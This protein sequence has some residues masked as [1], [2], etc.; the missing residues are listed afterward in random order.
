[1]IFWR[2][3]RKITAFGLWV[4]AGL[5]VGVIAYGAIDRTQIISE[6]MV[7]VP[8]QVTSEFWAAI[9]NSLVND[10][11]GEAIY[12]DFSD[13]NASYFSP[14]LL[15]PSPVAEEILPL[16]EERDSFIDGSVE[17]GETLEVI[18]GIDTSSTSSSENTSGPTEITIPV[19]PDQSFNE[20][21]LPIGEELY[22]S[23]STET[24]AEPIDEEEVVEDSIA[25]PE[26]TSVEFDTPET[27]S[28]NEA[29]SVRYVPNFTFARIG[30][31]DMLPPLAT[32][33]FPLAQ[34][35]ITTYTE[36]EEEE[37]GEL[38]STESVVTIGV[39]PES[40]ESETITSEAEVTETEAAVDAIEPVETDEEDVEDNGEQLIVTEIS[41]QDPAVIEDESD[42]GD[43]ST[44]PSADEF[45]DEVSGVTEAG[46]EESVT[47]VNDREVSGEFES[48][49]EEVEISSSTL[50]DKVV[51]EVVIEPSYSP[52][53]FCVEVERCAMYPIT[54]SG[55]A[56]PEFESGKF[57]SDVTLRLS[58]AAR[59][60]LDYG[61]QQVVIDYR[62]DEGDSWRAATVI[63]IADET[64][65]AVN[66]GYYLVSLD[67]PLSQAQLAT[68]EVRVSYLGDE[69]GLDTVFVESLW[70]EVSAASF[71]EESDP[72]YGTDA[73][74]Y[75]RN[76]LQPQFMEL[77]NTDLDVTSEE[78]PKFALSYSPQG[79]VLRRIANAIFAENEYAVT[80]VRVTDQ[81]DQ[82]IPVPVKIDYFDDTTWSVT[83]QEQPQKFVPGK[84]TIELTVNE[85][86]TTYVDE[87]EFYWG[88]LAVNT[89]KG[90]Y[91]PGDEVTFN[92]AALTD[93]GDTICD[94][95]LDL[96]VIT[97]DNSFYEVPVE[98]SGACG[99]NNVTDIPDYSAFFAETNEVGRY[100]IQLRHRNTEGEVIHKIE[101]HFEVAEY[102]PYVIERTA[103]TRIYPPAP[104]D[105]S[106]KVSANRSFTGD[107]VEKVPRGFVITEAGNAV[108]ETL[109][110]YTKI[111]W[112]NVSLE[113]GA[114]LELSYTFDAPDIS[115]YLY[116]LGPLSLDGYEEL[117][118]WQIASDALSAIASFTG[119]RTVAGANLNQ[120]ASPLEWSTSSLDAYYFDHATSTNS[121][122]VIIRQAGD[123]FLSA[124]LPQER[125][126]ANNSRTRVGL[127]V[128][129]NGVAIPEGLGRSGYIRNQSGHAESSSHINILLT[130]LSQD[131]VIT[132]YA[133]GLTTIDAGDIVNVSGQASMFL[134]YI[135]IGAGVFSATTT[136]TTNSTDLNQTTE[137]PFAWTETR[138]DSGFVHS[139]SVNPDQIIISDPGLYFVTVNIPL[140]NNI[141]QTNILGQVL[142]DGVLVPGGQFKQ[143][144]ARAVGDEN[145]GDSS[146]HWTGIV[147][148]TTTNQVLTITAQREARA[149]TVTVTSGS[150]GS[151]YVRELP[152]S[153][154]L[155]LRG[156]NLVGGTNWNPAAAA[157]VQWDNEFVND[158]GIFTHST[159]TN[160][161]QVTVLQ[162]G[163]YF[164][165]YNDALVGTV[166]RSNPRV[167]VLVNGTPYSGAETKSHYIRNQ[168][169]HTESSGALA[170]ILEG[171]QNGDV[172]TVTT[173]QEAAAGTLNDSTDALL[174]LWKKA[175]IDVRPDAPTTYNAPF[176]NIRFASTTPYFDFSAVD[177]D[178]TSA[179]E[180]EFS[181][182]TSSSFVASSTYISSVDTEF[183]NTASSSDTSP[184]TEGDIIRFQ[185][186]SGDAL[187]DLTTYYWR[188]RAR[189]VSGSGEFGDWSTTQ[190]LTVDLAQVA[191][192]WFQSYS[193]QFEGNSLVGT[194]SSGGD[195]V[196]VDATESS[197]I[198]LV[199]GEGS[200]TTPRYR[201]WNGT[202]WGVEGSAG[203]IGGAV[204]WVQTAAGV[205]RDE[206]VLGTVD[207]NNNAYAQIY[208]ASTSSWGNVVLLSSGLTGAAYR[209]VAVAY[210]STSGDAMAVSCSNGTN[211]V[212]RTWNGSSWSATSTIVTSSLNNCNFVE[213]ASDPASDE[214]ILVTR[215]TGTQYEAMVWDGTTWVD[216]R[217]IGSSAKLI[218]EGIS[219]AYETSGDQAVIVVSNNTANNIIYTTWNGVE[220]STNATQALGN[221]F[222]FGRLVQDPN[223]DALALCYIDEDNDIGVLRWNG[224]VWNT[225]TELETAGNADTG[226]PVD[227]AF[228][229]VSGRGDYI[230]A[231]YSDTIGLRYRTATSSN[232]WGTEASIDTLQDSFWV[233]TER[234]GDGTIVTVALD[235]VADNLNT[236]RW[237]GSS[238]S[239][240]ETL[241]T[242]LSS[243]IATPYEIFDLSAKLFQFS[244]GV[245]E[246]PPI[247]FTAVPNQPT[248]G[249]VTFDTTEPFGTNV[250]VRIKYTNV[251]TCDSYI[252]NG[253]LPGNGSGFD[254]TQSPIDLTGLSTSTYDQICLEATLTTQDSQSAALEEWT[255]SWVRQPKL[256]QSNYRW[257]V[258]GSFLTPS[259]PWPVGAVELA[260]NEALSSATAINVNDTIRLRVALEGANVTLPAFSDAFKLQFAEGFTCSPALSWQDVGDSASSTALWRGYENAIVGDDWY[261]ASWG[262]RIKLTVLNTMV[263]ES[264]TDFPVYVDLGNLPSGFFANVQSDGDDIRI[265][266]S[267]GVTELPFELV[268][269][270]TGA[271]T[272]ELHFKA[273]LSSTTDSEFFLYYNNP[274]ASGYAVT[275]TYGARNVWTNNF[276]LRYAMDDSPVAASPQFKDS[277]SNNNNAV[278]YPGMTAGDVVT[279]QL[280]QAIDL[281]G[282]DGGT[283][284]TA[285]AYT[286]TF[287]ASMWWNTSGDGFAIA[288]PGGANEKM[289]P[290]SSPANRM[291]VRTISSSDTTVTNPTDGT[292]AHVVVTRD[293]SNK[294]DL[295]LN[296]TRTRLYGDAAQSGTSDWV[297]F[298]GETSQGF[299]GLLDELR[300]A[301]VQRSQGWVSTEF[302]NQSN[303]IG[304]YSLSAEELISDGRLL[305][306]T[307]LANSDYEET[308]EEENPTRE[309]QNA[310]PVG[311]ESEWDFVLQN[312]NASA[313]TNYCFR[314][315]YEDGSQFSSY[316]NY[317]RLITNA[318]PLAPTLYAPFDNEQL[319]STSP[320]FEFTADDDLGDD[321]AYQIQVSTDVAFGSTVVDNNSIA[322]FAL[323]EN[324][325]QPSEKST[326]TTGETIRY[327][328]GTTLSNGQTYWWRVRAQDPDGSGA[329]GEWST[330]ESF[331]VNTATVITTWFQTTA[332][333][334][335]TNNLLDAIANSGTNDTG[336]ESGFTNA[337]TTSTVIDYDDRDTG[338]AWGAF[339]FNHNVTSGSISYYIE[340]NVGGGTFALVPDAAL[341][342]NSVGFTSSP[343]S[344]VNLNTTTYNEL[345]IR[346]VLTGN[347]T[348]PRLQDWTVTW[349]ETIDI[350]TL[351]QP[352]DNAK[353]ATTGP[354]FTFF[355]SDP[356]NDDLQYE[357]QVSGD[358][359]FSAP[360]TFTSGV[361]AGFINTEDGADTSPF[362]T[363]DVIQYTAQTA[364][365]N[366]NTYWWRVRARDPLGG[367][368]WSEYSSPQSFTVDTALTAS[369]WYQ[370]TGEQ[371]DT[372]TNTDIETT[373][374]GAQITS[375]IREVMTVYGE[376]TG[377][378]PQYRLWN[379]TSWGT[380]ASAE[381]VGAQIR[382]LELKA[383]PAR[384]E[385]ALGTLGSDLAVN[386]QIYNADTE[387]WGDV[388]EIQTTSV[389]NNK[390]T[391]NLAYESL[392]GD[393]LAVACDGVDAVWSVW[394]G[395]SW[396]AT[397]TLN[398]TNAN[399][400][401]YVAIASDPASDEIIAMFRHTNTGT[402]DF[403][404]VVWNGSTWGNATQL[405][406]LDN[407]TNEGMAVVYEE[408]GNQAIIVASNSASPN[409]IYDTWNG[410]A[411]AGATTLALGDRIEWANLKRDVGSDT[412]ALCYQDN[413][414]DIGVVFWDGSAWGTF[415]ELNI[416]GNADNGRAVD[417]EFET[418]GGRDG[419]LMVGYSSTISTFYQFYAT[420]SFSGETQVDV[421]TDTAEVNMVRA[422]DGLI[423]LSAYDDALNPDRIDHSRW[424]GTSWTARERF[425]DNASL[426]GVGIYNGGS[427]M[428]PQLYPNFT[429]GAIRSTPIDFAAGSGPRWDVVSWNDTTP[430]ASVIEYRVYYESAPGVFTLIPDGDL[431]GNTA[432]FTTSPIDIS[433]LD[434]T[435]YAVLQL[436]AQFLCDSGDC[437]TLEDWTVAWSEGITVSGI[438][439]EYNGIATTTS[440]SVAV[441]VNG[442]LQT[443]KTG[444]ILG[445]G[446]WSISNVT[447]FPGDTVTVFVDGAAD[448]DEA[449]AIAT[450]NGVGNLSGLELFKR[451]ISI[452]GNNT[453]TTTNA[454]FTGYD[455]TDDEDLFFTVGVG[456]LLSVCAEATCGDAVLRVKTGSAYTPGANVTT[457]NFENYGT[458]SP[459]TSTVRVAGDWNNQGT[460]TYGQSTVIFTATSTAETIA[461]ASTTISFYNLTFGETNGTAAWSLSNKPLSVLGNLA[462]NYG[463]LARATSSIELQGN[464]A[465]GAA[466]YFSGIGTTTFTGSGSN[467]WGD[468]KS[469]ASSTN[470]G[471]VVIDGTTKTVTLAGSVAADSVTI[472]ADDTLNSSGSGYT[473]TVYGAW[474]N[475]NAF[476][477]QNGTVNFAGTTSNTIAR[478]ASAF[479]NLTFSGVGGVWSFSS[480][481]L[482]VNGNLTIATGT[483]TLP[484]G[485]TTI[486]GSFL[487]TGGTF[488][489]NNGEVRMTSSAAGRT[490]TQSAT[491]FLNAFY[492]LAFTGSG[493]WSFTETNATTTRDLR[494]QSGTV[495]FPSGQL[496]VGGDLVVTGAGAFNHNNGEVVLIVQDADA[497]RTNG[498]SLNNVRVIGGVSSSWYD[499]NWLYRVPVTVQAS[500]IDTDLSN[501]P[502]YV[503]LD[504][505]ST[506]FFSNVKSDGADIRVTSGDGV[507]EVPREV[508]SINTGTGVGELHF[509]AD[510][511]S[512][513][514]DTTFYIYYGNAA[515]SDY[516]QNATY[517][518]NNVWSNGYVLV[519]HMDDLTTSSIENS[520]GAPDGTKTS[521]NNPLEATTGKVYEAQDFSGDSISHTSVIGSVTQYTVSAWFN[522]DNLTGSGDT[523]TYG[524]SIFGISPSGA[525]YNWLTAGGTG[526]LTEMRFC[527]YDA[528]AT[529]DATTGAGI[530][531]GNWH[532]V[533]AAA[534]DGATSTVRVNG[535]ERLSFTNTGNDPVGTNF[536]IG[537][538]RPGRNINFD[539]R[540]DEIRVSNV[541]RSAAWQDAEYRNMAT[542]TSFYTV[543][544]YEVPESRTFTDTNATI[545]G[546]L[547]MEVGGDTTF[548]T[549]VLLVGGSFD[550]NAEFYANNGVVRFNSTAGAETIAAG[551][552]EFATLEFNSATGDFTITE[553]ATATTAINLTNAQQFTVNSGLSLTSIGSFTQTADGANTTWAGST[554][555]LISGGT[556][557]LNTK[558]HGGDVYGTLEAASSTLVQIWNASANTYQTSGATGAIYSQDHA[559]VDGD[560]NIYGNYTRTSGTEHW[561]YATDFDGT[562]LSTSS[563]RQVDVRIASSSIVTI[564]TST[565]S[566]VGSVGAS[567]TVD[568]I[569]G[570]YD[571][572]LSAATTSAQYFTLA[573]MSTDGVQLLASTTLAQFANGAITV[574]PGRTGI[575]VDGATVNQN[576]SGQFLGITFATTTLGV[577]TNVTLTTASTNFIWFRSGSGNLYGEDFDA[578]DTDPGAIRFDDSSYII[579][580][581]GVVYADDG[582][583]PLGAPTCDGVTPNVRIVVD[584]GTY[585]D[586]VACNG[587]TG[588]YTFS[589]VAY[590][591]DPKVIVYLNT[592][593]GTKGSVVTKTPT[594]DVINFDV[595][596]NRVIVR[597][598]D[599]APLTIADMV[600]YDGDDDSDIAFFA[601]TGTPD[602]LTTAENTELYI[603]ASSTF[604]PS[605]NLN[606]T[607]NGN[608]NSYEGSLVLGAGANFV[609]NGTETHTVA[610][611]LV[612]GAGALLTPASSTFAFIATTTGKS[613]TAAAGSVALHDLVF[614][615][616]GGGWNIGA[617]LTLSG[618]MTVTE[619]AVTGT[620]DI[621]VTDGSLI[622]DGVLSLGSGTTTIERSNTFG[623]STSWTFNN[624]VLGNGAVIGTTTPAG[625]ATTTILGRLTIAN[626]H[627]LDAGNSVWDLAGTGTVFVETGT[628]LEDTSVVRY[629]GA[630]A[631][632]LSTNYYNLTL[633]AGVGSQT[634]T[635]AGSGIL[636]RNNLTVGG[637]AASVF[638]LNTSDVLTEVYGDL[639]IAA[640]GTLLGS[641]S[642]NLLVHGDWIN[643]G[644]YTAN[645]GVVRFVGSSTSAIAAG[646]SSFATV[647]IDGMGTFTVTEHATAT[648]AWRLINHALF[649]VASGQTLAV[650]GEFL[651]NLAGANTVFTG[652]T[653]SLFGVGTYD[654]NDAATNEQYESLVIASGTQARVWNTNFASLS[655]LTG[656]SLYSQDHAEVDGD[657]YIYGQLVRT[658]GDDYWSYDTD[659]DGSDLTGGDERQANVY[660]ANGAS[661]TWTGGSLSVL[662]TPAAST[663][664]QNQGSGTYLVTLGGTMTT[665][666]DS[667][668]VR[669]TDLAGIVFTGTPTVT[670][671]NN[672]DH[673]VTANGATALTVAGT[674]IDTNPAK[675]F[676]DNRFAESGGVT[677]PKNVTVTGAPLSSWRFTNH[678]G[679]IAGE[680]FDEDPAGDPGYVVWDD[681]AAL[682]TVAGTVYSDEGVTVSGVCDGV[683]TNIRLV[684]AGLT[685]YDATCNASTGAY[686]ISNV[687]FSPL[688]TLTLYINGETE[689]AANV[690]VSPISSISNMHLYENRVIVR[691]ENTSPIT[692]ADMADWDSGDDA[693]IP[694]TATDA[695][696]DTLTLP[697]NTKLIVWSTKT[698]APG[699]NVTV[700]G[701][702]AGAAYDGT[703]EVQ[704][705]A[706]FRAAGTE[707]HAVGGSFIFETNAQFVAA[708]STITMTTTGAARTIDT[709]ANSFHNLTVTG[710][711]SWNV[712]DPTLTILGSYTQS[713][714]AL[715]LPTGTTTVGAAFA[716]NGGSITGASTPFVFTAAG[717]GTT[718]R[719][720]GATVGGLTFNGAGS[721]NL[722]DTH[723]TTSGSVIISRGTVSLPSGSLSVA[724]NFRNVGGTVTHNTSDLI[725]RATTTATVLTSS[726][727][728]FA[729]RFVGGGSY[730]LEDISLTLLDS[731][732]VSAGD[733][734]I[735]TG[736][737]AVGGSF[738]AAGGTFTHTSGTVLLNAAA[739]GWIID[740]GISSFYNLQIGAPAG[741][742]TLY[743]ATTTNNFTIATVNSLTVNPGAVVTV[744]GVFLNSVGGAATTWTDTT[745]QL[746]GP[747]AYSVNSRTGAGDLYGTL[748]IGANAAVRIW[749]SAA[750]TTT[751]GSASSLYSQDH[752][753]ID[754]QLYIYGSLSLATSTE[755]WSYATDFDGTSLTGS[756]RAVTVVHAPYATT[757]IVSGTLNILGVSGN[758]TVVEGFSNNTY[759]FVANGG[760]LNA[761]WYKFYDLGISGL[762]LSGLSTINNLANGY[763]ELA[764]D[765]A[766][767][768]TLSSTTL[769]ANPSK[770]FTNVGFNATGS[771]SGYNINLVGETSNA[772]RFTNNYGNIGGEGF[773]IDGLDA[774]G[775]IRFDDSSCLL[776]EQTHYRWRNDDGAEGAPNSEWYDTSWQYRQR[777]RVLNNDNQAY[778]STA[779]KVAI[780]Y[781]SNMQSNFADLRFTSDDGVTAVPFWLE[782][783]TAST[784]ATVWV[785]VPTL[786][787]SDHAT[788][789]MYYGSSTASSVSN[790]SS[791]FLAFDD[792]EDNDITEYSGDTSLFTTVTSPAFGGTYA[793]RSNPVSGKTSD[794]IFRFDQTIAQGQ[795]IRYMQYVDAGAGGNNDEPCTLFGV[796]SPGTTNQNYAVCLER[797]G[798]DRI[799][800]A[801][802][803]QNNDLSGT[804]LATTTVTYTTGWYEVEIDW[805][806]TGRITAYLYNPSGTLVATTAAT[807]TAYTTGGYGYAYWYQNGA[808]D[809]FTTRPRVA[810]RPTVYLG[811]EQTYG[812]ASWLAPLDTAGSALPNVP[813]R[814]RFAIE[815]SGLD[816]TGQQFRLE[817]AAKGAAPTCESVSSG[818]YAA[819]PNQASCGT[820]PVCMATSSNVINGAVTTDLLF[821]TNGTF[822]TGEIV[823]SPGTQTSAQDV[824]Q[825]FYTE[826]EYA[827]VSTLYANDAYCFRVTDAGSALDF[828]GTV[829]ELGL[830]FDPSL[831]AVSLNEGLPI[832]LTPATTT[833][834]VASTTVSD[835]NGYTDITH[836]TATIYRSGAGAACS[837]DDNNCYIL[838]T[839]SG[840]CVF[841]NCVGN[842]CAL[843]CTAP[844]TFFADSTDAGTY[845]GQEWLAYV[846]VEDASA[847]YDF[848]SA[849]GVELLTLRAIQVDSVINFGALEANSD[850]GSNNASTTIT[851]LGNVPV[852]VDI[853]ATDLSDGIASVIPAEQ[854][855]VATGTFTYGAC[856]SC[857]QLSSSSPVT[858]G[859]NLSK[860]STITPPV[861]TD[862]YWGIAVPFGTN[863]AP[864]TGTNIFTPIGV[865]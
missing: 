457:V 446:T 583:T 574:V 738:S 666:W 116:L 373:V 263:A 699:G 82:A 710:S 616:V 504:D 290:W 309:N 794:G 489:H 397:S 154:I 671:F 524:Y 825:D 609:A 416:A 70:L 511:L 203:V 257:Y 675:N 35:I 539:G 530:S 135:G 62:Y 700:S 392:S 593:G 71:Y 589:N 201:F 730:A 798:T 395:T 393:L 132:V 267:D 508:V 434:R 658:V 519:H 610:G 311:D 200:V 805:Q 485:T 192:S 551:G 229:T 10:L 723:A 212:Y 427:S 708:S 528:D 556:V 566:M 447:A 779:V 345:R 110:E 261:N 168:Q 331:T 495:T 491:A 836:A 67:R 771:L 415:T 687:A 97:A 53:M 148:S 79:N 305:P 465:I 102:I 746:T 476:V 455:N 548:P 756:E 833:A 811:V 538:L 163:D 451:H 812:G 599:I 841:S 585:T 864:H 588:A 14:L 444:T 691:H 272:G 107:V 169:G 684:V 422:G 614:N 792:Y 382:W 258:N 579:T 315:V 613:I 405:G 7:V 362:F 639:L 604:T 754:G 507:T 283:F 536:T 682:I 228:E 806:T 57:L 458:F 750:A 533:S 776:T 376:G 576:A 61:A 624:L 720:N 218:R 724:G 19:E 78:L 239:S 454:G 618:D 322:Q 144:Y 256:I 810:T 284:Q 640:N 137:Y 594:T 399:N 95:I 87:F 391:F 278:A 81:T 426:T 246:T 15:K 183:F 188:V 590:V 735:G 560:L 689:R 94:A 108:I 852:N 215:D 377:Q 502:V 80:G 298:G 142:L 295:Y 623:G 637:T 20:E 755:H 863:S 456:N 725:L 22:E 58:L 173:Q 474:T 759:G 655:V 665:E 17:Q 679:N 171:L 93:E 464:L 802:D 469:A 531:T 318:P 647:E 343:V 636:A 234:A 346:A 793:L 816:I 379:G 244:E 38:V 42:N 125:T 659:F 408:S 718:V 542:T 663:T 323:F 672:T 498:S 368:T 439:R 334:F 709:N 843:Q 335:A 826:V 721:W 584:G 316:T 629:S 733:V 688:D 628:F 404:A 356:E 431:P 777:V 359:T 259:D 336:I 772:W 220:F 739:G 299:R 117:R 603:F 333:Q 364:L 496:T 830:Q 106:L 277:T 313:A 516:A 622:G 757:T 60:R 26:E 367:N 104:Y 50:T 23:V 76:L 862:V 223:S 459:A 178:G 286:G 31:L 332:D 786:P 406:N 255:L 632:I 289:G 704:N 381:S 745:L 4:F 353:V 314:L 693:D 707:A 521:A 153:D 781:D 537:D 824:D 438:A 235:D 813:L 18:E 1:M 179:I 184:F 505:L 719:F 838:S 233:R 713:A 338:N 287:T 855:K 210:E 342:G 775:S 100:T 761:E 167:Q 292:W 749:Y 86:G 568:A 285:L 587:I 834:V 553:H 410:S 544:G 460:F 351:V 662:G 68:L 119:T 642:T 650:G 25:E 5:L 597:H 347:S 845:E 437:P 386:L 211:L 260:E 510:S 77:L 808:W 105:V 12:Q 401:E 113:E 768:I 696:P 790:G 92:L 254:V 681:S 349:S 762:E 773:D 354:Q 348:L 177:P 114:V 853:E 552:S 633:E 492:D 741:E 243:T 13:A 300:F 413:D 155:A 204:N 736:T 844:V 46:V 804:V 280:G 49:E 769:N 690:S 202:T 370:T 766:S 175:T 821:G 165:S 48:V 717:A 2:P 411:W 575:S 673:L 490:I 729:L 217:V 668:V 436:D 649:T 861:E 403:E 564:S 75:R 744:G 170:M 139:D 742:Y 570:A 646:N 506:H 467:T 219:V 765:T 197:E 468:A 64:S 237:N 737:L 817:Y 751:L 763:F 28:D 514:T 664:L 860:P 627:F 99:K 487:N 644:V 324:L 63:D 753:N 571:L 520:E 43:G 513:V 526:N 225:F 479:N 478:G 580:V 34:E 84:Y 705:N 279:G 296:G 330:P 488:L 253:D 306:S 29:V 565:L 562:A 241:E 774:C 823:T 578:G 706:T 227:C 848:A 778:A 494:I 101:N 387:T 45:G 523:A 383:S 450:Y 221:D 88:V 417:C 634:Y 620:G 41:S 715:T 266:E 344:L 789:F 164:L 69:S 601:A 558:T 51:D 849:S 187:T 581:S 268:A 207:A 294:V 240:A 189:D 554:L 360:S 791:T 8:G 685:T 9:E 36:T 770:T 829:A 592:N 83:F 602:T 248:W 365:T 194:V 818:S 534:Y 731:F 271:E 651:N 832:S 828:Y 339:S 631:T 698:F 483:V 607:G 440:G 40:S 269:I 133:E 249:D 865:D 619:G 265:T 780:P 847:G 515:A 807:S 482:A 118:P 522:P 21:S 800:I 420:S 442:V 686:S 716:V 199:Y 608:S 674:V 743:S 409:A 288:G 577:A 760:A 150:V 572:I 222:E 569:S 366:G 152:T 357:L 310:L 851:N 52:L 129:V 694:F 291:F 466:G 557:T 412:V 512:S 549:G 275:A 493:A 472:G 355:T 350:P 702:G 656:G 822:S 317:P 695:S 160:T 670:S 340:Y 606:L 302:N 176:D 648:A 654:I 652:S 385:Y 726:S 596:A 767:L 274:S 329:Y 815:N 85:N 509:K 396:S 837:P 432:G 621:T 697:A 764:L 819:I 380:A 429:S 74:T 827:L 186:T 540:I 471:Y 605:G 835:F 667:V 193:G 433:D 372:N 475:N 561:S 573:G 857:Y 103:P 11:D 430:G 72:Y 692:I 591:G 820:S 141:A 532:F 611:R 134:E 149:G 501:F 231:T 206:Y 612:L 264:V 47:E 247:D 307:L 481:T 157:A 232:V 250:T 503:N 846:E 109:P 635:A 831:G 407:N 319:A 595:Y 643:N 230:I 858:L 293:S 276:S 747:Y 615:G 626:A 669:D 389:A 151:V 801:R 208:S 390:R 273:D 115:P 452:G 378:A 712:T 98:S 73:L 140:T 722:T 653:L 428:A 796:Q 443:G 56:V 59:A 337:T 462:V 418:E 341:P 252:P 525:P 126:D 423:H 358:Y 535:V 803:V 461:S 96:T 297:N 711:G 480:T 714:G 16:I 205:T 145:D 785:R 787:A 448:A 130:N 281:D 445:D 33:V 128:R 388:F 421:I 236:S 374:G 638:D 242:T 484:T 131:D 251:S 127:E 24:R 122:E 795:M 799:S 6:Q 191:P 617:N 788:V 190:S 66:G 32:G 146:I 90:R 453:A 326:F 463:T 748:N 214:I 545:L 166:A 582:M 301:T 375:T 676:T 529:C 196:Q 216:S 369:A 859:I 414:Q 238:W 630:G 181:I 180:Y 371:F 758:E 398:L 550:N 312:N 147:Q 174:L 44:T 304:F 701:G 600:V 3:T 394:N 499:D 657:L 182:S 814:L 65:N 752:S 124:N 162:D 734:T 486:A 677:N 158:T 245:M 661:A 728:L 840:G 55:F 683:T 159:S 39:E 400:C 809:S 111:V 123:Y 470:I 517:G 136:Q 784:D 500:E 703:L 797:F 361:N 112:Q 419:Y 473:I 732:E 282:N 645:S 91:Y 224:G 172:I 740:P 262:R 325:A 320:W 384:P 425:T 226:R 37:V 89:T 567:T 497:I 449:I 842:S 854:Q 308:Y 598:E 559:G 839:E 850:T 586:A 352:F 363:D 143:G 138:Q 435:T 156:T 161:H 121:H 54:Y 30:Q 441:A 727:D 527:S 641:N 680:A 303:P 213:L 270:D 195:R 660:F 27:A 328:P 678:I 120:A 856:V 424:D 563:A 402:P 546:N 327:I 198:L 782:R 625:T 543:S 321:V 518:E 541:V 477:P 783:Y 547:V 185:L 555:R 209:G